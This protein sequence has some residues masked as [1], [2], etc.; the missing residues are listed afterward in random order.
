MLFTQISSGNECVIPFLS[1]D[2]TTYSIAEV[3]SAVR[4]TQDQT[5]RRT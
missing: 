1:L 4:R 3:R 2:H 5:F